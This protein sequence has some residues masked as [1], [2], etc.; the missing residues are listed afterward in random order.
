LSSGESSTLRRA[1]VGRLA[2][3]AAGFFLAGGRLTGRG[4]ALA[5]R[6]SRARAAALLA[7][8]PRCRGRLLSSSITKYDL[9]RCQSG[10]LPDTMA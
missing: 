1:G 6:A 3:A 10:R 8:V 7:A 4:L 5:R 2:A 9:L